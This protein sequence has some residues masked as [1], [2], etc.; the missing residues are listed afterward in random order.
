MKGVLM[1]ARL[2]LLAAAGVLGLSTVRE[3]KS[4]QATCGSG[5]CGCV[6]YP[7]LCCTDS[8][9]DTCYGIAS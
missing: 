4:A 2:G 8:Q 7:A 3:L 9:G 1:I 6:T 5:G